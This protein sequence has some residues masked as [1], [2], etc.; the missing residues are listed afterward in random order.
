MNDQL[1]LF[2]T[3]LRLTRINPEVNM[4][5]YYRL[6]LQPSLFGGCTLIREWGRIGRGGQVLLQEFH[7]EGQAVDAL[8]A[9]QGRKV[10]KGYS[11]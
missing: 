7:C 3:T 10:R 9:L 2:P 1:E 11:K 4:R 6:S 5:R 8:L